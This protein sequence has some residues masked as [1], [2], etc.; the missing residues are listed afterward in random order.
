MNL[1]SR[2]NNVGSVLAVEDGNS[3][4]P[5]LGSGG[6]VRVCPASLRV[7]CELGPHLT[8]TSFRHDLKLSL[9]QFAP[10]CEAGG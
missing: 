9:E 3:S 5:L 8:V 10:E 1:R 6:S 2:K 4:A 7:F